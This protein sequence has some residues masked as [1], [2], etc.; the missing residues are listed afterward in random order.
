MPK[1]IK[2]K[3]G[4]KKP[5]RTD[6][7]EVN[8]DTVQVTPLVAPATPLQSEQ[9]ASGGPK[10][11]TRKILATRFVHSFLVIIGGTILIMLFSCYTINDIKDVLLAESGILSG[12]LG[13]IIG[14]YFK[15]E[16]E[17]KG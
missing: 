1:T 2:R 4:V 6:M 5:N 3:I 15:E 12:P 16:L 8:N 13:F 7:L 11:E 17:K 9:S 14:F 10:D